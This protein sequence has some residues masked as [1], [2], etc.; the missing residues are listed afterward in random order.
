[1]EDQDYL[2]GFTPLTL[3]VSL[4]RMQKFAFYPGK[5]GAPSATLAVSQAPD[6]A[7]CAV[8]VFAVTLARG[9]YKVLPAGASWTKVF[10]KEVLLLYHSLFGPGL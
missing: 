7:I 10:F 6:S 5:M 1:M 8:A 3:E 9:P 4:H 2:S